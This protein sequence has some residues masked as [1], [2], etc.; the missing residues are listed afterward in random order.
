MEKKGKRLQSL[1]SY[2]LITFL[3]LAVV[4]ITG[5][6]TTKQVVEESKPSDMDT[7][8]GAKEDAKI[9]LRTVSFLEP[10]TRQGKWLMQVIDNVHKEMGD[11]IEF[12]YLGGPNVIPG[13][14]QGEALDKNTVDFAQI[15]F[16]WLQ[17]RYP[18]AELSALIADLS[19]AEQ[20]KRGVIKFF[21]EGLSAYNTNIVFLGMCGIGYPITLYTT[22]P[23]ESMEDLKGKLVRISPLH[24]T[25]A[26]SLGMETMTTAATELYSVVERKVV[27]AYYWP[28][29]LSD[30]GLEEVTT[31]RI[32]PGFGGSDASLLIN[33]NVW[34][35]MSKE[36][37]EQFQEI[38][39]RTLDD[40][41]NNDIAKAVEEEEK[42]LQERGIKTVI[43]PDE[44]V[45]IQIEGYKNKAINELGDRALE[46]FE[47]FFDM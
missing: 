32:L 12:N 38:I 15:S 27:D 36:V 14:E 37:Q 30:Y 39:N 46:F 5:C 29:F 35:K 43:F 4:G 8:E 23:V 9:V 1:I 25:A 33:R 2:L 31:C 26:E 41:Y 18:E 47:K 45:K 16:S 3:L 42:I 6:S 10:T 13:Y 7:E 28:A 44:F 22:F 24:Q 34:N 11:K 17:D 40:H 20:R 21:N 19:P